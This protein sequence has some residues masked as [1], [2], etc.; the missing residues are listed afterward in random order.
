MLCKILRNFKDVRV[1]PFIAI[2]KS[3]LNLAPCS[4]SRNS[5][6]IA[7]KLMKFAG[8]LVMVVLIEDCEKN[9][10]SEQW[11]VSGCILQTAKKMMALSGNCTLQLHYHKM[12]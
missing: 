11:F 1:T 6:I 10:I 9:L 3:R 2:C 4:A 5:T 7:D 8:H 12:G